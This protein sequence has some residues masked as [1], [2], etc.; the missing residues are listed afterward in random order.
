MSVLRIV[1]IV[2]FYSSYAFA[3]EYD[4]LAEEVPKKRPIKILHAEPLYVDLIRD[5]GAH[6]GEKEWNVGFGMVDKLRF[7]QYVALVEYEWAPIDRLGLEVEIPVTIFA[8][9]ANGLNDERPSNRIES[10]KT[11]AQWTLLVSEKAQTSLAL[12]YLN[13]LEFTDLNSISRENMF[14]GNLF[15]PF[16]IAA[17][18]WGRDFHSLV[19]TGPQVHL[20]F[21]TKSWKTAF[22]L[23][24]SF[25]Y[26]IPQSRNFLGVE[27]NMEFMGANFE[28]V[29]RP[30]MRVVIHD[31][32]MIGIVQG[33]PVSKE[34]E[35]LSS[36]LRLIYEP[37][38]K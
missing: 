9:A 36:F 1:C 30:Q 28:M 2:L 32:L 18:K 25:H 14:R 29:I 15:N 35:R 38:H 37:R 8:T 26:M 17:K 5:L 13:E 4:S 20:D 21:E 19:Y 23:N 6:K 11:A 27:F 31:S 24:S 12:G 34:R 33:I 22:E 10:I 16:F 7:D 3:Q